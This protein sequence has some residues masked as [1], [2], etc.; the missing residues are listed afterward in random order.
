MVEQGAEQRVLQPQEGLCRKVRISREAKGD[1]CGLGEGTTVNALGTWEVE[2]RR[3]NGV[4][5]L[6]GVRRWWEKGRRRVQMHDT[7]NPPGEIE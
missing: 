3:I 6:R 5:G 1:R 2:G 4:T 7:K